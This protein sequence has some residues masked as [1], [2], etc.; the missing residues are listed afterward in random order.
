[1]RLYAHAFCV[2][3][4]TFGA[5]RAVIALS[6]PCHSWTRHVPL[7]PCA[8]KLT[9]EFSIL[10]AQTKG[11]SSRN[12]SSST[13]KGLPV[14]RTGSGGSVDHSTQGPRQRDGDV[15]AHDGGVRAAV[16]R[17]CRQQR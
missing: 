12:E 10:P 14:A 8:A 15:V 9:G 5:I 3:C 13:R 16:D 11:R 2:K 7:S 6:A 4:N 17:L 1:M